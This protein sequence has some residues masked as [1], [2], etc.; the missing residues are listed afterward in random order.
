MLSVSRTASVRNHRRGL[1]SPQAQT[2]ST[3]ARRA[4]RHGRAPV[5]RFTSMDEE[6]N[7]PNFR[8][9]RCSTVQRYGDL[10][11]ASRD[12]TCHGSCIIGQRACEM[13]A[14]TNHGTHRSSEHA[15]CSRNTNPLLN[16][17]SYTANS[18][19]LHNSIACTRHRTQLRLP[20][21][22]HN[23]SARSRRAPFGRE[24]AAG[25]K[26]QLS[27]TTMLKMRHHPHL[28]EAASLIVPLRLPD[29][30]AVGRAVRVVVRVTCGVPVDVRERVPR[31]RRGARGRARPCRRVSGRR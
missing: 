23:H 29:G 27:T 28:L 5:A 15:S 20:F 12:A 16:S 6:F 13:Q 3:T 19:M 9:H 25:L 2:C 10:R 26:N 24:R 18:C 8:P 31:V 14:C 4:R 7:K 30:D 1:L 21:R 17:G 22:S 11:R